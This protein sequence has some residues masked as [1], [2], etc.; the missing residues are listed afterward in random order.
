MPTDFDI[1]KLDTILQ[2]F[3]QVLTKGFANLFPVIMPLLDVTLGIAL[4]FGSW[5]VWWSGFHPVVVWRAGLLVFRIGALW[6][7]AS[8]WLWLSVQFMNTRVA[9]G[10]MVGGS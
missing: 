5:L 1:F 6:A 10:L 7:V 9:W 4:I 8:N 2:A 3:V